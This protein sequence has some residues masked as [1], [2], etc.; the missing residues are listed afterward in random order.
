M[1]DE[2]WETLA[3]KGRLEESN[4]A[5]AADETLVTRTIQVISQAGGHLTYLKS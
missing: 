2:E 3:C 1:Q 5:L 4:L